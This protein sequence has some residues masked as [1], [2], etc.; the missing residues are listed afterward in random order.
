MVAAARRATTAARNVDTKYGDTSFQLQVVDF[1]VASQWQV[2]L[3]RRFLRKFAVPHFA[4]LFLPKPLASVDRQVIC[5]V[6]GAP[7]QCAKQNFH[8]YE[9]ARRRF[10]IIPTPLTLPL[11]TSLSPLPAPRQPADKLSV[12]VM[13]C[14]ATCG[15]GAVN[16]ATTVNDAVVVAAAA[17]VDVVGTT[18][19]IFREVLVR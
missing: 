14:G 19:A 12:V 13:M 5:G 2:L 6:I 8:R 15:A 3:L 1:D 11:P 4:N 17:A 10:S 9:V 7:I 16:V 18:V